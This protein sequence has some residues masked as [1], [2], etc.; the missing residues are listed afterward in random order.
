MLGYAEHFRKEAQTASH[1]W[2]YFPTLS[3]DN[4]L[5]VLKTKETE[6]QLT[7]P[8]GWGAGGGA[9]PEWNE[10]DTVDDVELFQDTGHAG[11]CELRGTGEMSHRAGAGRLGRGPPAPSQMYL[12]GWDV[13]AGAIAVD[14]VHGALQGHGLLGQALEVLRA[15]LGL[16]VVL[17]QLQGREP[18]RQEG[19]RA[20]RGTGPVAPPVPAAAHLGLID[21]VAFLLV[22]QG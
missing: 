18:H 13:G 3:Y 11:G 7:S 6:G 2:L 16:L 22:L 1:P 19:I 17:A 4:G 12:E 10:E 5:Y 8:W 20:A 9:S 15:L 14:L 21:G